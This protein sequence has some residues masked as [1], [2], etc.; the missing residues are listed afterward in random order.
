MGGRRRQHDI[1]GE[2]L[3]LGVTHYSLKGRQTVMRMHPPLCI[4]TG[5]SSYGHFYYLIALAFGLSPLI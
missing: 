5:A 3:W 2:V 1:T 4:L